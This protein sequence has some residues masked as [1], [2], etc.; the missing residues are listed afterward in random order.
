[1]FS[2]HQYITEV[3]QSKITKVMDNGHNLSYLFINPV[4]G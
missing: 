4:I 3:M 1:M 2:Y